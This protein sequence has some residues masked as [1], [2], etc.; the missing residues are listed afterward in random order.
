MLLSTPSTTPYDLRFKL[1]GIPVRV[2][3]LFWV[4]SLIMGSNAKPASL[5]FVWLAVVFVSILVHEF[6]HALMIRAFGGYPLVV[7]Y[8]MGGLAVTTGQRRPTPGRQLAILLAGPGAGLL[9]GGLVILVLRATGHEF[10]F[11]FGGPWGL[12]WDWEPRLHSMVLDFLVRQLLF[13]NIFWS[14]VNLLPVFPLDGGQACGEILMLGNVPDATVLSLRIS[15]VAG[16]AAAIYAYTRLHE[17]YI[18]FLFGYL[19]YQSLIVLQTYTG[20][21]GGYGRW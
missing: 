3:P 15:I 1:L 11:Q 5:V 9:L 7:L 12:D 16:V 21:G 17:V 14:L 4:V 6:G 20:R 2:H 8:S 18:T 13:V 10:A 19:A